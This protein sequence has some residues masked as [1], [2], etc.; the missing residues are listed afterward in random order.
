MAGV[1]Q[2]KFASNIQL[3]FRIGAKKGSP[4]GPF[5]QT[6]IKY[7]TLKFNPSSQTDRLNGHCCEM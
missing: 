7:L 6:E 1:F 4:C 5:E 2:G 3:E